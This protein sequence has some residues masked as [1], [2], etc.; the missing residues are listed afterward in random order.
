MVKGMP[1]SLS[2]IYVHAVFSTKGRYPFLADPVF[3]DQMHSYL[4]GV[5]N[6][7][8]CA[9][10]RV[11]GMEDHVHTLVRLGRGICVSDWIKELK[12]VS[13]HFAKDFS[14]DFAW[15]SGYGA[16]SVD[17]SNLEQIIAYIRNQEEHH[18]RESFKDEFL[19]LLQEHSIEWDERYLWD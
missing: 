19:R 9:S 8:K 7:L 11:G 17:P 13:S 6:Q 14:R 16:F 2:A 4:G 18:H 3:R 15:Q 5:N 10:I 1:Q 12:R